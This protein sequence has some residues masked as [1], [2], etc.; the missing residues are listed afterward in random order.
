MLWPQLCGDM[1][2]PVSPGHLL[3]DRRLWPDWW[4]V[5]SPYCSLLKGF[6]TV[7]TTGNK[8]Q[9]IQTSKMLVTMVDY[10]PFSSPGHCAS[11]QTDSSSGPSTIVPE[12][13]MILTRALTS[14][15]SFSTQRS[16]PTA[17]MA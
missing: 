13:G 15:I 1:L 17:D 5:A 10:M 4:L 9:Q 14:V 11:A 12:V 3:R 16:T 2:L 6:S 7:R 8:V